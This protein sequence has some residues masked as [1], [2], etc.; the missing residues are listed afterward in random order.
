MT[1]QQVAE[2][3]LAYCR[4]DDNIGA[5]NALYAD[6]VVSKEPDGAPHGTVTGKANVIKKNEDWL[7]SVIEF[8]SGSISEPQIAGN[9]F[10]VVMDMD[11][12]YKEYGRLYMSEIAVY[13]VK[14]GQI[15][16]EQFFY[17]VG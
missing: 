3:L 5:I 7:E 14:D 4:A 17:S 2:K 13:E 16:S 9:F 11:V 12:T 6:N 10:S 15:V 1:T 8:H